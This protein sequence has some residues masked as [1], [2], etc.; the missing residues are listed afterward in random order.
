M[1]ETTVKPKSLKLW[2]IW[3]V[4]GAFAAF[5]FISKKNAPQNEPV[6]EARDSR[7]LVPLAVE[8]IG[9]IEILLEGKSYRF[10][11]DKQG[12]WFFHQLHSDSV[13]LNNHNADP[14]LIETISLAFNFLARA[15]REQKIAYEDKC[16]S[17]GGNSTHPRH[18]GPETAKPVCINPSADEYG[19]GMPTL[20]VIGYRL[21][22]LQPA[23]NLAFG[24]TTPD[25]Y[26]RYVLPFDSKT[27]YTVP[28][29]QYKNL[30]DLI[31]T[32]N[33]KNNS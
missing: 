4:L 8:E 16:N 7:W 5:I 1:V 22:E 33:K 3:L 24:K 20:L 21:N 19:V 13:Q 25:G 32:V 14:K 23:F 30:T 15:Q 11:R 31:Q 26:S 29:F 2:L 12:A 18:N 10:E 6:I 17:L 28:N 9:S 27:L